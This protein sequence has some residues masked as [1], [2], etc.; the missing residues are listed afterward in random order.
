M[1]QFTVMIDNDL[2]KRLKLFAVDAG[3]PLRHIAEEQFAR[4][5][6]EQEYPTHD[7][8]PPRQKTNRL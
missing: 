6:A 4:F 2:H 5:L 7:P 8:R 3:I 1:G